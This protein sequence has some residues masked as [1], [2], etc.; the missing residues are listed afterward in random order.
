M[1]KCQEMAQSLYD[2]IND[3]DVVTE[4]F[5]YNALCFFGIS[6]D[7][8]VDALNDCDPQVAKEMAKGLAEYRNLAQTMIRNAQKRGDWPDLLLDQELED[9]LLYWIVRAPVPEKCM[10]AGIDL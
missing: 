10:Q 4:E 8:V 3:H 6:P 9:A 1:T 5:F 2:R 7:I